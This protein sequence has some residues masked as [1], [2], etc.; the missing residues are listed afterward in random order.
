MAQQGHYKDIL[1]KIPAFVIHSKPGPFLFGAG[2][3]VLGF[4]IAAFSGSQSNLDLEVINGASEQSQYIKESQVLELANSVIIYTTLLFFINFASI[5][6]LMIRALYFT[7]RSEKMHFAHQKKLQDIE[8]VVNSILQDE[9]TVDAK[10]L[11][12]LKKSS[13][14][15]K[16]EFSD[17]VINKTLEFNTNIQKAISL[18]AKDKAQCQSS[19]KQVST[20]MEKIPEIKN[21]LTEL[22]EHTST[23]SDFIKS[24]TGK[25]DEIKIKLKNKFQELDDNL[26]KERKS[27]YEKVD[28]ESFNLKKCNALLS[29]AKILYDASLLKFQDVLSSSSSDLK[30]ANSSTTKNSPA[31]YKLESL[32]QDAIKIRAQISDES[33]NVGNLLDVDYDSSP[34]NCF[35]LDKLTQNTLQLMLLDISKRMD[36]LELNLKKQ[37]TALDNNLS[38]MQYISKNTSEKVDSIKDHSDEWI[39]SWVSVIY[40]LFSSSFTDLQRQ[41]VGVDNLTSLNVFVSACQH[42]Q[43]GSAFIDEFVLLC[44]STC[45]RLMKQMSVLIFEYYLIHRDTQKI[46]SS[47][48]GVCYEKITHEVDNMFVLFEKALQSSNI[49]KNH[50]FKLSTTV[51]QFKDRLEQDL[52]GN[53]ENFNSMFKQNIQDFYIIHDTI[54]ILASENSDLEKPQSFSSEDESI[55][56]IESE[57]SLMILNSSVVSE[58]D[59]SVMSEDSFK[60]FKLARNY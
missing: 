2:T 12:Y 20:V 47:I 22:A 7:K 59:T 5:I 19:C 16:L 23:V 36:L 25:A 53:A 31:E 38:K 50:K 28:A 9:E 3:T 4:V 37:K 49:D 11:E 8:I 51:L 18:I 44:K 39:I 41:L 14:T 17:L 32:L 45:L 10:Q 57:D 52:K 21:K 26:Q 30:Y 46:G 34:N 35:S 43:E 42:L 1:N 13:E 58:A 15:L 56:E 54:K 48:L 55:I 24:V 33:V 27:I 40:G 29:S 60:P 6:A